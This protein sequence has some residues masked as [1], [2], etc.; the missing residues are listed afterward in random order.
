MPRDAERWE[1]GNER[2][3]IGGH[4]PPLA[5]P[6]SLCPF[7]SGLFSTLNLPANPYSL[8]SIP[9]LGTLI[10]LGCS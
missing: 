8:C 9:H 7:K 1:L 6:Y 4:P 10:T 2:E 3:E 5:S